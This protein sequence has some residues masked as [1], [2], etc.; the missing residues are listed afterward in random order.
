MSVISVKWRV[1][2]AGQVVTRTHMT[3]GVC[4]RY[5]QS[6]MKT[7]TEMHRV[8]VYSKLVVYL[9]LP[10]VTLVHGYM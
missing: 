2:M 8:L 4:G 6:K 3:V 10:I 1:K 9:M 7:G 5:F